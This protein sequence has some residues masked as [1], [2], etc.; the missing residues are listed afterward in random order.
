MIVALL[1]VMAGIAPL[2]A[3]DLYT[4]G[5]DAFL[6]NRPREAATLFEEVLQREPTHSQ[7]H[8]Y[9]ATSYEQLGMHER[10]ISTLERGLSI[11]GINRSR[12][13]F[14]MGNNL[15]RLGRVEDAHAA[16]TS[17]IE[18]NPAFVAPYLNRANLNVTFEAYEPAIDDYSAV[19][20]LDPAHPQRVPI[21][22]MIDLLRGHIDEKVARIEAER[23]RAE[24]AERERLAE[25]ERR[26]AEEERL[27]Q[28]A[29]ARRRALLSS[30]L[31]SINEAAGQTENLSAGSEDIDDYRDDDFDIAD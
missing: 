17:A 13:Y 14:N 18:A 31:D 23:L 11:P 16:Y 10:A 8:F 24:A 4:R 30:V 22:Q 9:L 20:S 25:E 6:Y 26:L 21:R 15:A 5:T 1:T 28:E 3:N 7:A 29:E 27:R 12:L 19:L 2:A